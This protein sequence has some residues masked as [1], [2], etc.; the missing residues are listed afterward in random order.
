MWIRILTSAPA[1][2]SIGIPNI[3]KNKWKSIADTY[4]DTTYEKR[5]RHWLQCRDINN[6]DLCSK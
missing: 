4:F 1:D 2:K 6:P 5:H 3:A